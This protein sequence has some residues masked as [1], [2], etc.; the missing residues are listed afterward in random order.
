VGWKQ[1]P[2]RV[3]ASALIAGVTA[4]E[5]AGAGMLFLR[6][7]SRERTLAS[8]ERTYQ[9]IDR[10]IL[11]LC[12]GVLPAVLSRGHG[13]AM[14]V[15][16]AYGRVVSATRPL[17][18]KPPMASFVPRQG[19]IQVERTLT[20]VAGLS[21]RVTVRAMVLVPELCRRQRVR[22][23]ALIYV[24]VPR[25]PWYGSRQAVVAVGLVA[26]G[27]TAI[28]A[29][30]AYYSTVRTL[31]PVE[32]IRE[33]LAEITDTD[34][35]RRIPVPA[36]QELR[37]MTQTLNSTLR[38][39]EVSAER[40]RRFVSEASHDLRGPI[41]SVRLRL[42][43]A[44]ADP[45]DTDWSVLTEHLLRD[46]DRQ[47]AIAEDLLTLSRLDSGAPLHCRTTDLAELAGAE[48]RHRASSRIPI[49]VDLHEGVIVDCDRLLVSR[50]LNN[51]LDNAQRHAASAVDVTV[52]AE[53]RTAVLEVAD[54]GDGI[55]PE[56]R[57]AVFER[58]TRLAE[59][60]AR[61]PKGTGLGLSISRQIAHAHRGTLTI[62]DRGA[63]LRGTRLVLRIP[64]CRGH[65]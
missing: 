13:P 61:D 36:R 26:A 52:R 60:R 44:L 3:S 57:D 12:R 41:T 37:L 24:A 23:P 19:L 31:A 34:L 2:L 49:G 18:G 25:I 40:L 45:G 14:Q 42:E 62:E 32:E 21:G 7:V 29:A 46:V 58:F 63:G 65:D 28:A 10:V 48:I 38:R 17:Q 20:G 6:L 51:L 35:S 9:A 64:R 39:L 43:E 59:G 15:V 1:L 50:L 55:A 8:R 27:M 16:D 53:G 11:L 30:S 54:D 5:S 4:V 47:Q 22:G 56:H 33:E